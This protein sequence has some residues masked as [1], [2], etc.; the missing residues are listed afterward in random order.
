KVYPEEV[1]GALKSFGSVFDALVIGVPDERL[2]QR[3]AAVVQPRA[4]QDVDLTELETHLRAQIS[5]YK[6]PRSVWL[7]EQISRTSAGKADYR[8]ARRFAEEQLAADTGNGEAA[9]PGIQPA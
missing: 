8:W 1:E 9:M 7:V 6:V 2:G 5:G 4:G 3:V